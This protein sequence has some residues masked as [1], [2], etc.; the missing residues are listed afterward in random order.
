MR[1]PSNVELV[2]TSLDVRPERVAAAC[3]ASLQRLGTGT[4]DLYYAH[5][6]DPAV[7][8]EELVGAM[9]QFSCPVSSAALGSMS[10]LPSRIRSGSSTRLK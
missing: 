9:A 7:P 10:T 2:G 8:V 3:D 5:R 6:I 1:A 4:I